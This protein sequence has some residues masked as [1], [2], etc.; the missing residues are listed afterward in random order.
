MSIKDVRVLG[1]CSILTE[2]AKSRCKEQKSKKT[3][4]GDFQEPEELGLSL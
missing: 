3:G 2:D 4:K 1:M